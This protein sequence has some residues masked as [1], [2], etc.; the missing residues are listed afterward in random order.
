[1]TTIQ[2]DTAIVLMTPNEARDCITQIRASLDNLR[3]QAWELK[4]REGWRALGY[5][6]WRACVLSEFEQSQGQLYRLLTAAE[7]EQQI[8]PV[9]PIG[10][11]PETHLRPLAPIPPEER[12]AVWQRAK[13]I[14]GTEKRT[15]KHV[16]QAV[17]ERADDRLERE[18]NVWIAKR[19][20]NEARKAA[21]AIGDKARQH[22]LLIAIGQAER[23][24]IPMRTSRTEEV[25]TPPRPPH[26]FSTRPPLAELQAAQA[27]AQA[28]G[29]SL[30]EVED[31]WMLAMPGVSDGRERIKERW[32]DVLGA[33]DAHEAQPTLVA[34]RHQIFKRGWMVAHHC[35]DGRLTLVQSRKR[36][37]FS[38]SL[39]EA[40]QFG[41]ICEQSAALDVQISV[42]ADE[43]AVLL[44]R[45]GED[46]S[47]LIPVGFKDALYWLE[48]QGDGDWPPPPPPALA[49]SLQ[50]LA[51]LEQRIASGQ[52]DASDDGQ[53][54]D[55]IAS[56]V[57]VLK[58]QLDRETYDGLVGQLKAA[59][60]V[61]TIVQPDRVA[62]AQ[63][64]VTAQ[65]AMLAQMNKIAMVSQ[66]SH[67]QALDHIEAL[68][69]VERC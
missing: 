62:E 48:Q 35:D 16:Q 28:F 11:I 52:A 23:P 46:V 55:R 66:R 38:L 34:I 19:N 54:L 8:A 63:T 3:Q 60:A 6:S 49:R 22:A 31:G 41:Q 20:W 21:Y 37:R 5:T 2:T 36:E 40:A 67:S 17:E 39:A 25:A 53:I 64:F 9:S 59:K 12:P 15:A 18:A 69:E 13:D 4:T 14:A 51:T 32:G 29:G 10:E 26:G 58:D 61:L 30:E 42:P 24:E 57:E 56:D 68:L 43:P 7:I 1:M 27:R 50:D 44:Y 65:R 45:I 33:M 47:Q